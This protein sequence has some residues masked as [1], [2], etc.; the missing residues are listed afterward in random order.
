MFDLDQKLLVKHS[1]FMGNFKI[2]LSA[3]NMLNKLRRKNKPNKNNPNKSLSAFWRYLNE[4][5]YHKGKTDFKNQ[6][7][8]EKFFTAK[9]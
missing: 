3:L 4:N 6:K 5:E 2:S 8:L 7:E 9:Q 1:L